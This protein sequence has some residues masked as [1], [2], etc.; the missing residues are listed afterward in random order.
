MCLPPAILK[1]LAGDRVAG[2]YS[3]ATGAVGIEAL[4]RGAK[5][6]LPFVETSAPSGES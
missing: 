2:I 1:Q 3:R 6:S 5:A 4:S